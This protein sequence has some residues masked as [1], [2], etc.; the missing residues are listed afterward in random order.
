MRQQIWTLFVYIVVIWR[1]QVP[2]LAAMEPRDI[3]VTLGEMEYASMSSLP[4]G[5]DLLEQ[6]PGMECTTQLDSSTAT[7][8]HSSLKVI[9]S[10]APAYTTW[11]IRRLTRVGQNGLKIGDSLELSADIQTGDMQNATV[12][13]QIRSADAQGKTLSSA[14]QAI[15]V[16]NRGWQTHRL[17]ISV[18]QGTEQVSVGIRVRFGQ[19][20]GWA[21]FWVDNVRLTNG[22][23]IQVPA[24]PRRVIRTFTYFRT[25]PDLYETAR[26]FDIVILH[27]VNWILARP[28]HRYNPS[29]EVYVYFNS[30]STS[31]T[32]EGKWD[33]LEYQYVVSSRP[34]WFLVDN[35]G[36]RL[37]EKNYPQ[38]YLVDIG[39]PELQQR[40]ATRA[41]HIARQYGFDGVY[42]DNM[43]RGFL[44]LQS[45]T[46]TRYPDDASYQ[47][48]QTAFLSVVSAQIKQAGLKL[49]ANFGYVWAEDEAPY[50]TWMRYVDSALAE[51]WVRSY[52]DN[53]YRFV[54]TFDKYIRS[55]R[56]LRMH[57]T[58]GY[59]VQGRATEAETEIQRFL[60]ATALL[61]HDDKTYFHTADAGYKQDAHYLP[62]Y[63][64]VLGA[65]VEPYSL[66]AGDTTTGGVFRRRFSQGL[67]LVNAHPSQSFRV[68]IDS[69]YA[70]ANGKLYTPGDFE[71]LPRHAL[72]LVNLYDKLQ[73]T[74]ATS[75]S[76]RQP[77]Q[78][79]TV[80]VSVKNTSTEILQQILLRIPLQENMNYAAG[81]ASQGGTY[82]TQSRSI[83][84]LIPLL[85]PGETLSLSF[86]AYP[87]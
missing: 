28:L 66:I 9:C 21:A 18:P 48:A 16:P 61:N 83:C 44:S 78:I 72:I 85:H 59:L 35:T 73:I 76:N 69:L 75:H 2:G 17:S 38:N 65:P 87:K 33:P 19:G 62:D 10:T 60:L 22:E 58:V 77:G 7:Q 45:L 68:T 4:D 46:S 34:H 1:L 14:E 26:R 53:A 20:G 84:W 47:S 81:S 3:L 63:E 54:T 74:I 8:G 5:W 56:V 30:A 25:H 12:L 39:D 52:W 86:N 31:A 27:P 29:I 24:V 6:S 32:L 71:L 80:T 43:V 41:I 67:V 13:L 55:L 64:M 79:V 70:D 57:G 36:K 11:A 37:T 82:D 23:Q 49:L 51:N 15:T 42:I 50:D 40:W